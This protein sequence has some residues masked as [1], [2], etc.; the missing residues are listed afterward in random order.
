[1]IKD[2]NGNASQ[3]T[4]YISPTNADTIERYSTATST[5]VSMV[6]RSNYGSMMFG[7][8]GVS[9]WMILQNYTGQ[10]IS[11]NFKLLT[12][13]LNLVISVSSSTGVAT[14]SWSSVDYTSLYTW[15]L[16]FSAT[17]SY[18]DG[19]FIS[20][21]SVSGTTLTLSTTTATTAAG[22]YY[23]T[24]LPISNYSPLENTVASPIVQGTFV[25]PSGPGSISGLIIWND[26]SI[27]TGTTGTTVNAWTNL[28]GGTTYNTT[29]TGTLNLAARNSKNTIL[30][31]SGQTWTISTQPNLGTYSLFWS[32]RQTG[33]ANGRV[34]Q[35]TTN[36]QLYGY[37]G[38]YKKSLYVDGNPGNHVSGIGS[39][40]VWDTMS[41][42]R[43]V[44]GAY[45]FNWDGNV[46]YT[47]SGSASTNLTGLAINTGANGG[48]TSNVEVGEII[49]FNVVLTTT[50]I[51]TLEGYLAW[52]WGSQANLPAGHPYKSAAPVSTKIPVTNPY[53][54]LANNIATMTWSA[55]SGATGYVWTLFQSATTKIAGTIIATGTTGSTYLIASYSGISIGAYYYFTV[56]ATTA[57][58]NSGYGTS[59]LIQYNNTVPTGGTITLNSI[60]NSTNVTVTIN[61]LAV[62][63]TDYAIYIS[64]TTSVANAVYTIHTTTTLT[65]TG[66]VQT[67][68]VPPSVTSLVLYVWGAGGGGAGTAGG[69]GAFLT[70]N[71]VVTPNRQ[72]Y[73]FVGGG[74]IDQNAGGAGGY[75]GGGAGQNAGGGGGYSGLFTGLTPYQANATVVVGGGGG[76]GINPY[77]ASRPPGAYG[78]SATFSG[79]A[80]AGGYELTGV[81]GGGG[82]QSAG[83]AAGGAGATAGSA[84]QGGNALGTFYSGGGGGGYWG[85]GGGYYAGSFAEGGGGGGSSYAG[86]VTS[87]SGANTLNVAAN[88]ITAPGSTNLYYVS[89]VAASAASSTGGNG[90]VT[91]SSRY[92]SG[93][94]ISLTLNTRLSAAT[95]YYAILVPKNA[96]GSGTA[97][98][99]AAVTSSS[100]PT[101][102][103]ITFSS[104]TGTGGTV[105]ITTASTGATGYYIYISTTTSIS[106]AVF[107]GGTITTLAY[108]GAIQSYTVP[109]GVTSL[110]V[111]LWGAGGG[112]S[113][114]GQNAA[115]G[116]G[117][118]ITGTMTVTSGTTYYVVVGGGGT[119]TRATGTFLT[120]PGGYGGGGQGYYAAGGGGYSGIFTSNTPSQGAAIVIAGG[121]GGAGLDSTN[122]YGGSAIY[123]QDSAQAGGTN[124]ANPLLGG[125]GA[126][127]SAGGI[128]GTFSGAS[129]AQAGVAGSALT[130]GNGGQNY[131]GG[132]GGGYWGGGGGAY[133][134][135]AS[136]GGG[137]NSFINLSYMSAVTGENSIAL[138]STATTAP[139]ATNQ[140]YV[141]GVAASAGGATG[142]NGLV[143]ITT[144]TYTSSQVVPFTA[145]MSSGVTYYAIVVPVNS[146]G[147]GTA[148]VS[149]GL[150]G[151]L[152]T[153]GSITLNSGLTVTGGSVTITAATNATSYTVYIS[154]TTSYLQSVYNFSTTTTGSAVSF[155]TTLTGNTTYYAVLLPINTFGN[156]S[157]SFSSGV[158]SI[159]VPT[160]GAITLNSGL[161]TTGGSITI[162]QLS[163]A[164]TGY[165]FYIST[166]TSIA[167][168]VYSS[169]M[170]NLTKRSYT[171]ANQ[172]YVAPGTSLGVELFGAGGGSAGGY[173]TGTL[174]TTTSETLTIVVGQAGIQGNTA[175]GTAATY[176]GGGG[177]GNGYGDSGGGMTSISRGVTRIV[178]AGGGGGNGY[179]GATGGVGGGLVG[180]T[181]GNFNSPPVGGGGG[182]QSAGGSASNGATAGSSGQGGTG[183]SYGGGGGG[184][185]F[186]GGGGGYIPAPY[187]SD[188][189]GG[190]GSSYVAGLTG[191]VLNVQGG[192]LGASQNGVIFFG[193]A[194]IAPQAYTLNQTVNF[195]A[196]LAG[197]TTYY[198]IMIPN[199]SYGNGSKI[200]SNAVTSAAPAALYTFTTA[201]FNTS[202][203]TGRNG[204]TLSQARAGMT[205]TPA[206]STWNTNTAYFNMTQAG[207]QRWTVPATRNY[208]IVCA[209]AKG[210]NGSSGVA[211][212][213]FVQTATFSL[214]QGHIISLLIGQ[215]G[216]AGSQNGSGGGGTFIFNNTTST[217]LMASGGGG[218]GYYS[219]YSSSSGNMNAVASTSGQNGI[220]G[221]NGGNGGVGGTGGNG[222]G[223]S[224]AYT[225]GNGGGGGGYT[226]NGG[227]NSYAGAGVAAL[228]YTNGGTGGINDGNQGVGGFGGGG[229][230]EWYYWTGA[231]GGGGYSG[232]GGGVYYG[233]GGGGGSFSSVTRSSSGTNAGNGY[234]T[235]T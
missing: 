167:D 202:G 138:P 6:I 168:A 148:V 149:S 102:G 224:T 71:L 173:V 94:A 142:G 57:S 72:Y 70:G 55:Y 231:G 226:G 75:S 77:N 61:S 122:D 112:G 92:T 46:I 13:V 207:Y 14:M 216:G 126:T 221:N 32:G 45:T 16:Y 201:T 146:Y 33:G 25:A 82:T 83:G 103:A 188:G 180:G 155:S 78:G 190:G 86:S 233:L 66:R 99:S 62:N 217:L 24:V 52:K 21:G 80:Q 195:T 96:S 3:S 200:V 115:G 67:Y 87:I 166:T 15:I 106:G 128:A 43:T 135:G 101:G 220:I 27:L 212:S 136:G 179:G 215:L 139:A 164:A 38:G 213:G 28:A 34:L 56:Y 160:G 111:Y 121:G 225:P 22:Y 150:S 151:S 206:P 218:G 114:A 152:P 117:S 156:G 91:V 185:Y 204:P 192:G 211:G 133:Q 39:D 19:Q 53:I 123:I 104:I 203:A 230:A 199:N 145:T 141:S 17:N 196:T 36:N 8:D 170:G 232:G 171:G 157:Y 12:L 222:G 1:M 73:V 58:A 191:N 178:V 30:I 11:S 41:H 124:G 183:A 95:N 5:I 59:S 44:N 51:Q 210:G 60:A 54:A 125:G 37:W 98:V 42:T 182:T 227:I 172:T 127:A 74:G 29:T 47:G 48:E 50:D 189:G 165:I 144:P 223:T 81:G 10:L 132:G 234:V 187:D 97:V 18:T 137:G 158:T 169:I 235:I 163:V 105:T 4:I 108:T 85:G 194:P 31:T 68:T 49:L 175:S 23:F 76:S 113:Q 198:A 93:Q 63:A 65:Y 181:G 110:T 26:A 119:F 147:N 90:L 20:T 143:V 84:L 134:A 35:S 118:F 100:L 131:G 130:G 162:T 186:G 177:T 116:A 88:S 153:G 197:T 129:G 193:T 64:P 154:T 109:S 208:T 40:T 107:T 229:G 9:N 228:S 214:T 159:S 79:T 7:S 161:Q 174:A 69:A 209:G 219:T 2:Q 176:G 184:G 140:F 205:G 89:G 120:N